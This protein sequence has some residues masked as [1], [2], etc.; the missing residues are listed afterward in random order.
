M[1]TSR[2]YYGCNTNG[3]VCYEHNPS[4]CPCECGSCLGAKKDEQRQAD[5]E[6]IQ[7]A[8]KNFAAAVKVAIEEH[9]NAGHSVVV[10]RDGVMVEIPPEKKQ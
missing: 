1:A 4:V 3:C 9:H 8:T 5:A 10:M 2:Y 7:S 6:D